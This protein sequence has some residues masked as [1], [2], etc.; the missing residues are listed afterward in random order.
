MDLLT[1]L[2]EQAHQIPETTEPLIKFKHQLIGDLKAAVAIRIQNVADYLYLESGRETFDFHKDCPNI[3]PPWPLFFMSF[4]TFRR[5][6][7]QPTQ[8]PK[9]YIAIETP[10]E[11]GF[12]FNAN[13]EETTEEWTLQTLV[14]QGPAVASFEWHID[15]DGQLIPPA[16]KPS[17]IQYDASLL[18]R[19]PQFKILD[20][21]WRPDPEPFAAPFLTISFC[22]CKNVEVAREPVPPKVKA[23]REHTYGWSPDAWHQ[24]K[25]EPMRKQLRAVGAN[26]PGGLKRAL[27]IMRGHFKDYTEGRGLFG[28]QHGVWWWDFRLANSTHKHR[29]DIEGFPR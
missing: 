13:R 26:Q 3:A 2:V 21:P 28:K 24:L 27:H 20:T 18:F 14:F 22:H 4:K 8:P 23:K 12:L 19:W 16:S 7:L 5:H 10:R 17:G 6:T 29:Y 1:T 9:G 15:K 25:I 11:I